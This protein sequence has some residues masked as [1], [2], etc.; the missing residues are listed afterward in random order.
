MERVEF[1]VRG[2]GVETVPEAISGVPQDKRVDYDGDGFR[3]VTTEQ[4]YLRT[5]SNLQATTIIELLDETT[6]R[7]AIISGGGGSGL[8]GSTMGSESSEANKLA[9]KIEEYC[10]ERG[11]DVERA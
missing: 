5:N 2:K 3:V 11:L 6:C 4:Y 1:V 8:L 9:R 7:V 10:A